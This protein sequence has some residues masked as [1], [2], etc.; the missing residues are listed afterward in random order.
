MAA[1]YAGAIA[2]T[3][4]RFI[5]NWVPGGTERTPYCFINEPDPKKADIEGRGIPWVLFEFVSID[6][7]ANGHGV[8]GNNII[9]YPFLIKGH[10]MVPSHS[11]LG[12]TDEGG[13]V[14]ALAIGEIFRNKLFYDQVTPGCYV[15]SG[16]DTLGQ[17][18]ISEGDI[19]SND[20]EWFSVTAT[21]PAE[22]WHR[23]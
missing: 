9:I 15:R 7:F 21:I 13:L 19:S 18:R 3:K 6:S 20:G 5:D 1:D 22:Y 17:P 14:L 4:Q 10:V 2:A 11:G 16:Y 23:G 12:E 8:P